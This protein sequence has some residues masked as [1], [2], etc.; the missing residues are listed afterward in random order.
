MSY[1]PSRLALVALVSIALAACITG[2]IYDADNDE[3]IAT[4]AASGAGAK[5]DVGSGGGTVTPG[6]ESGD[7]CPGLDT[8]CHFRTCQDGVCGFDNAAAAT[9]CE[10]GVCDGN[11]EC[12]ECLGNADCDPE[13]CQAGLCVPATCDDGI[14][15]G[16]ESDIDCGG[17]CAPCDNGLD[18]Q[19][20]TDCMSGHCDAGTCSPC[21]G[22]ND[23]APGQWCDGG[24]CVAEKL[25]GDV[26]SSANECASG[27]CPVQ[28]GVCCQAACSGG[29][30]SCA[31]AKTGQANGICGAVSG[32]TDP[33]GEC[34]AQG[35][36]TCQANGTGC[37]GSAQNPGCNLYPSGTTCTNPSCTSGQQTTA[38]TCNGTGTCNTGNSTSCSPYV[39]GSSTCLTSCTSNSQCATGYSCN[40]GSCVVSQ[41]C[42][43]AGP[44]TTALDTEEQ[45]FLVLINQHRANNGQGPLANCTSLSRAAQGHSEDMRDQNYFSHTGLN[46][47]SPWDR[48][49]WACYTHACPLSTAM[50]E[51]IAAGNSGAQGTFNQWLNSPGHNANMLNGS[52]TRIGIG[53][54]TGGGTYGSYWTTVFGGATESSC[55]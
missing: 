3:S 47:S 52:F 42:L 12:V 11:G 17:S 48:A 10:T 28:D 33:D 41:Q 44:T 40:A 24:V 49:C 2:T 38:G 54:A 51:N 27:N 45:A 7:T 36:A 19:A 25:D 37:N 29:C 53:R 20:P 46:G 6:C 39:C 34:T 8:A 55:N 18:C 15:S 35:A 50:A 1:W 4:T 9:P 31:T 14:M 26:C 23:C 21:G 32:G 5:S 43:G 16:D 22:D 30:V 13:I